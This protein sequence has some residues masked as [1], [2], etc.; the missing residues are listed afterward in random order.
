MQDK[1]IAFC[2]RANCISSPGGDT[3]QMNSWAETLR[4]LGNNVTIFSGAVTMD[5]LQNMDAV[6]IWHLERLTRP[7]G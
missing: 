7:G 5:A 3:V 1:N 6:F 4:R 2:V